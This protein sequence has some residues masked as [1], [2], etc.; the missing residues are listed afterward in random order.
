MFGIKMFVMPCQKAGHYFYTVYRRFFMPQAQLFFLSDQ[1]YRDF[2]DDKLMQNKDIINGM[3]HSRP[4][5][6]AF[7]DT[8]ISDIY[9]VV[10]ISS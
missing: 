9:W 3:P 2:P 7:E 1:Y 4:C 5:F 8:K 6:F 10:P